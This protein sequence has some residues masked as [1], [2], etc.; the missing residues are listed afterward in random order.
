MEYKLFI[1]KMKPKNLSYAKLGRKLGISTQAAFYKLKGKQPL[2]VEEF[3]LL[4]KILNVR[5]EEIINHTDI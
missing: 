5:P 2:H 4:C 3:V 1:D